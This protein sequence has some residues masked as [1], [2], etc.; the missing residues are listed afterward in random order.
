MPRMSWLHRWRQAAKASDPPDPG[1]AY[2]VAWTKE[3]RAWDAGRRAA[4]AES[5][6]HVIRSDGFLAN[7]YDR[8]YLVPGLDELRHSGAS[9]VALGDVLEALEIDSP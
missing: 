6:G 9:L 1:F 8:R 3:A 5:L 7:A 4:I 2:R